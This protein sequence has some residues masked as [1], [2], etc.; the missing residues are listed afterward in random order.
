[1]YFVTAGEQIGAKI[2]DIE[3]GGLPGSRSV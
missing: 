1:M 2:D 3:P